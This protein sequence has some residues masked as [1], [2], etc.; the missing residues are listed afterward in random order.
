M[1]LMDLER[2]A[3]FFAAYGKK[4][5]FYTVVQW[6]SRFLVAWK[7]PVDTETGKRLFALFKAIVFQRKLFRF[8]NIFAT[9]KALRASIQAKPDPNLDE[10]IAKVL[11]QF[12]LAV[13]VVCDHIGWLCG[14]NVVK[15]IDA[16]FWKKTGFQALLSSVLCRTYLNTKQKVTGKAPSS[17]SVTQFQL[18]C[19]IVWSGKLS[20]SINVSDVQ[21]SLAGLLSALIHCHKLY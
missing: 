3:N 1:Q 16:A 11:N 17:W 4:D 10:H 19:D 20:Q 13:F 9:I 14:I 21:M 12:F 15:G 5:K 7:Y 8:G 6:A 2:Q 18:G